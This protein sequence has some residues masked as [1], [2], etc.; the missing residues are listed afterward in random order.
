LRIFLIGASSLLGGKMLEILPKKYEVIGTYN[1]NFIQHLLKLDITNPIALRSVLM[2]IKPDIVIN[3]AALTNTDYCEAHRKEAYKVN[4]RAVSYL[5]KFFKGKIV[6]ISTDYVFDGEAG[7]YN[8]FCTPRPINYYGLTK[9]LAE[10]VIQSTRKDYL[11]IRV[12]GLYGYN[13]IGSNKFIKLNLHNNDVKACFDL[14]SS[15]TLTDDVVNSMVRLLETNETGIF[16]IAGPKAISRYEF[17][18]LIKDVFNLKGKVIPISA[19]E[20][21]FVAKRPKNS[22]LISTKIRLFVHD[23]I[24]GLRK[25]SNQMAC[26]NKFY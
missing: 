14:I 20:M 8:E 19:K 4:F 23:P 25:I 10:T 11:I 18:C 15:P 2:K 17:Q 7:F 6:Q 16:H 12:S 13:K 22:S 21:N 26:K 5:V 9:L 24:S 1:T 3:T